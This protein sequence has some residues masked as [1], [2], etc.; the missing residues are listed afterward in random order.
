VSHNCES[1]CLPGWFSLVNT[2]GFVWL[3]V[4]KSVV[5]TVTV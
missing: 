1:L 5:V 4:V 3:V 2:G